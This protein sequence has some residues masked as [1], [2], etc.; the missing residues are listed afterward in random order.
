MVAKV[1]SGPILMDNV[2]KIEFHQPDGEVISA[3]THVFEEHYDRIVRYVASRI[4]NW[5]DAEDL[6]SETFTKALNN[7]KKF[8]WR[9]SS[10]TSWI[11]K[12]AT[13]LIVDYYRGNAKKSMCL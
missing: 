11:Y 6:A 9:G 7:A 3:L 1:V 8:E 2:R 13:N 10:I 12:I 4:G 5:N